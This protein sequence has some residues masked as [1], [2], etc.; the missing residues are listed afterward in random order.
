MSADLLELEDQFFVAEVVE[1]VPAEERN[2]SG[3][4]AL[5]VGDAGVQRAQQIHHRL[6][7]RQ[8][9][10]KR[11]CHFLPRNKPETQAQ[12]STGDYTL[13]AG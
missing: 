8:V 11:P 12:K 7:R 1:R 3:S 13:D 5:P 9:A 4:T 10:N 6:Q 2:P